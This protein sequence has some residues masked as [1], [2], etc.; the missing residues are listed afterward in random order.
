MGPVFSPDGGRVA[1]TALDADNHWDSWIVPT[2]RGEAR[3]WLENASGLSWVD[4]DHVMFSEIRIG[5]HMGIQTATEN[6]SSSRSVYLPAGSSGMAHRSYR[7]PDGASVL[8]VE[9]DGTWQPCRIVPFD[10]HSAG[11]T[12]GPHG[13]CTSG[14]WSPDGKSVYLSVNAGD[15]FH[16][17]RQQLDGEPEQLT[18]GQTEEE[19]VAVA[20]DGRSIITSVGVQRRSVWMLDRGRERPVSAEGY[21]YWPLLSADGRK[22]FYRV[23]PTAGTGQT[24][25][26]LWVTDLDSGRSERLMAE[27]LVDHYDVRADGRI[28][29]SVEDGNGKPQ[30]WLGSMDVSTSPRPIPGAQGDNPVFGPSGE[31]A[32]R[33]REDGSY[34]LS[35]VRE[36]GTGRARLTR[37]Y[38]HVLGQASP[39]G[40]WVSCMSIA[41]TSLCSLRGEAPI[42]VFPAGPTVRLRWSPD[43]S[44]LYFSIQLTETSA[45]GSGRTYV[46]P[47]AR[48]AIL[49]PMPEGGFRSEADLAAIPGVRVL[50]IGDLAPGP[51]PDTYAFSKTTITRNLYRVPV[52]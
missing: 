8:V 32:F 17:W 26:E 29:A 42:P 28:V 4:R 45:F 25:S 14:A 39:D 38:S 30:L 46:I 31:I 22:V 51:T 12:I 36:D 5:Q 7:S 13:P 48:G 1:Y 6:R 2:V 23:T 10:G 50:Q 40:L 16:I 33:T 49:P 21:A 9:M 20:P 34:W 18:S 15:G 3:R 41:A 47:L 43:G 37:M 44:W 27:R 52:F 35:R 19:G 11:R 24:P